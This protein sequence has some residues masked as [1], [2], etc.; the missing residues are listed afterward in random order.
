MAAVAT[1]VGITLF[2]IW[3]LATGKAPIPLRVALL[4]VGVS[5]TIL[6]IKALQGSRVSWAFVTATCGT[7]AII[8]LFGAPKIRDTTGYSLGASALPFLVFLI[9]TT[10]LAFRHDTLER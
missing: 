3:L 5:N 7:L 6:G 1:G 9:V 2:A 10:L 4:L 8:C